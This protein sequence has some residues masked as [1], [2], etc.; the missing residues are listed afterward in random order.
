MRNGIEYDGYWQND[1]LHGEVTY[2]RTGREDRE[3]IWNNGVRE[4]WLGERPQGEGLLELQNL[5]ES[6]RDHMK[7]VLTSPRHR[8][9]RM[10][11]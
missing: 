1:K 11:S 5:K 6:I 9:E 7:V 3:G 2:R 10:N 8:I 4:R